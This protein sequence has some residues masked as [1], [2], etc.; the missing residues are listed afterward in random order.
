VR[1][2]DSRSDI[3]ATDKDTLVKARI[4]QGEFRQQVLQSWGWR[5]A[6]TGSQTLDAIRAS[7]IKSWRESNDQERLDP[8]NGIP[9]VATLDAL[10]DKGLISFGSSGKMI[11]SSELNSDERHIL[12]IGPGALATKPA[13]KTAAY[14][15]WH[16]K[17][18][19]KR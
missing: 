17:N 18:R 12:G 5:C 19:F 11:V 1:E 9:L 15:A 8:E 4:G 16:R 10:F 13:V 3:G 7:H 2:V 14:L 6:V